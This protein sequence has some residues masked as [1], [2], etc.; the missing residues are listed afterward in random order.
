MGN[1]FLSDIERSTWEETN[2][3]D[4]LTLFPRTVQKDAFT[5]LKNGILLDVYHRLWGRKRK[6]GPL[7]Y[8]VM[9]LS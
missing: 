3:P 9:I 7:R 1:N 4:F 5:S 2:D 6:V 8:G